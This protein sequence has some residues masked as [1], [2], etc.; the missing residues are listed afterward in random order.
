MVTPDLKM[1]DAADELEQAGHPDLAQLLRSHVVGR[2]VLPGRWTFQLVGA[3]AR[4]AARGS[5][6]MT[7]RR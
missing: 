5:R 1:G 3:R 7:T 4:A 2:K 6:L